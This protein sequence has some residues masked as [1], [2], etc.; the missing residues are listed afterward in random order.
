MKSTRI[1]TAVAVVLL[2]GLTYPLVAD[3][4]ID[5]D[6]IDFDQGTYTSTQWNTNRVELTPPQVSGTYTSG[7]KDA[8]GEAT[9]NTISWSE[10]IPYKE[11]LPDN[12]GTD[13]GADMTS[14]VLLMHLNELSGVITDSSGEGNNGTAS[15]ITYGVAG[16]FNT[17]LQ[18]DGIN[19]NVRMSDS[20]SLDISGS[21]T[22][23][24]WINPA[25]TINAGNSNMRIIDKQNA[26]YLLFDYPA[27]DGRAKF[28]LR[29]GGSYV[30]VAST[31]SSWT[32]GQWYHIAGTYDGSIMRIYV[33]GS[34][35]NSR[36]QTGSV[37][38][39]AYDL[40]LGVRAVSSVP[41]N[42]YF[43]GTIDEVAIHTTALSGPEILDHYKRGI[44]NLRLR[45]R[46]CDDALCSGESWSGYY[47]DASANTLSEPDN[48]YFQYQALFDTENTAYS[49][50][51]QSVTV[52][53]TPEAA[54]PSISN[55]LVTPNPTNCAAVVTV[56]ATIDDSSTGNTNIQTAEYFVGA[57]GADGTGVPMTA[58][59]GSFNSPTEVVTAT[60]GVTGWAP[61]VY[62]IYVHGQDA[63]G[64]WNPVQSVT[65]QVLC[66]FPEK[67]SPVN[68]FQQM[69]PLAQYNV[70][71]AEDLMTEVQRM[72]PQIEAED[73]DASGCEA[74]IKKAEE[75]LALAESFFKEGNYIAA[76]MYAL[77][78]VKTLEEAMECIEGLY[79]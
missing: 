37:V 49:P 69:H 21:I 11:E 42:M 6:Q 35:E 22:L 33:N 27:A 47:T 62:T 36:A 79:G 25:S 59:D 32:V 72:L 78:A 20:A 23:E 5:D 2:A 48:R 1:V 73:V 24:A 17:G 53:Y 39:S 64:N 3:T 66:V 26:Y 71:K 60:I 52:D 45:V 76:N 55:A 74:I 50:E 46:S 67:R 31:T 19:D 56:T 16:K 51:M 18:F 28:V 13:A 14:N 43:H 4:F 63:L 40:F 8:L 70:L 41:T 57:M 34:L 65:L 15:G 61:G 7:I 77:Q 58:Q 29:I 54:G 30:S 75:L 10:S 68:I 44:L 9:W 38:M 12:K